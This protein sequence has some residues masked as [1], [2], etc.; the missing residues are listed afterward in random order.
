MYRFV[1]MSL[2]MLLVLAYFVLVVAISYGVDRLVNARPIDHES[3]QEPPLGQ[4]STMSI[5]KV[6]ALTSLT[7][8][9]G[10]AASY[11]LRSAAAHHWLTDCQAAQTILGPA[12]GATIFG[13]ASLFI[14]IRLIRR[15]GLGLFLAY[16]TSTLF[17]GPMLVL[18]VMQ[19]LGFPTMKLY[20]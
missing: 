3:E 12:L 16:M 20:G 8:W 1:L 5:L 15:T 6:G 11:L 2:D 10:G 13:T 19:A 14:F 18:M 9:G 7:G 4:R 17:V